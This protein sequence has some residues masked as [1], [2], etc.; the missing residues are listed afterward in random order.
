MAV[1]ILTRTNA[2]PKNCLHTSAKIMLLNE[3]EIYSMTH[4]IDVQ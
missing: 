1:T 3:L 2:P 4:N